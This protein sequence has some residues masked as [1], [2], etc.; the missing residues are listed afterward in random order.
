[1]S[2]EELVQLYKKGDK[3]ALNEL[4]K[5][6]ER[7]VY[8]LSNKFYVEKS[9]SIDKDDLIQEGFLG[10]ILAADKYRFDIKNSCKFSTYAV[11]WIY[12]KIN[13]FV[14]SKNTNEEAS[15]N[16]P[17]GEE[18]GS[19]LLDYIEGVDY[20]FEN[21]E[22]KIYNQ[23]LRLELESI[24]D[25]ALTL[26]ER[27]ILKLHHG[28]DNNKGMN[29]NEIGELFSVASSKI[30]YIK[31]RAYGKLWRTPWGIEKAREVHVYKKKS[32]KYNYSSVMDDISFEQKYLKDF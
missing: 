17:I 19:E 25:K 11:Y 20:S 12:Q 13:R 26:K 21:V 15:L 27:E 9:N 16:I 6:N 23:E 10:L 22:E 24:M 32:R 14:T 30:N 28:W 18:D 7:L 2:N 3:K 4:V 8:K 31:K 1:M 5:L 29:H